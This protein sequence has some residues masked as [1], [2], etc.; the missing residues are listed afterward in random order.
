MGTSLLRLLGLPDD[1]WPWVLPGMVQVYNSLHHSRVGSSPL[2][3]FTGRP[4]PLWP[5][6]GD[7][8]IHRQGKGS[9]G[10][11]ARQ[12]EI[13]MRY[14]VF[15][16]LLHSGACHVLENVP[17]SLPELYVVHLCRPL[18]LSPLMRPTTLT[19]PERPWS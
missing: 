1:V 8:V 4:P 18:P 3:A 12:G 10:W 15:C 14:G 13:P 6:L 9:G 16:G 19:L 5:L 17:G 11:V 2:T 7:L